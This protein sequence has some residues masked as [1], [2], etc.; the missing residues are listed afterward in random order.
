MR[1]G[2]KTGWDAVLLQRSHE[3]EEVVRRRRI[4]WVSHFT[5]IENLE[6]IV[7]HG[8]VPRS[9]L[10]EH[11]VPYWYSDQ[12]RLDGRLHM[13]SLSISGINASMLSR[14]MKE[15]AARGRDPGHWIVLHLDPSVLWTQDCRFCAGNA[16]RSSISSRRSMNRARDLEAMFHGSPDDSPMPFDQ[17]AEVQIAGIVQ[18][19]MI[20]GVQTSE[21]GLMLRIRTALATLGNDR[22]VILGSLDWQPND[23]RCVET[24]VRLS[25]A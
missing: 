1:Y 14:K 17:Q 5:W 2:G 13:T 21:P 10:D 12:H 15:A 3:I 6:S 22:S 9:L 4:G 18:P 23:D 25:R 24:S 8:L 20:M 19:S 7:A 16:A 11:G